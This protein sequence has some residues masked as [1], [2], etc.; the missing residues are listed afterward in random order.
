MA[1]RNS[2]QSQVSEIAIQHQNFV[3]RELPVSEQRLKSRSLTA[4]LT[5]STQKIFK[6]SI[7]VPSLSPRSYSLLTVSSRQ[8]K[9]LC[10]V[11]GPAPSYIYRI[12]PLFRCFCNLLVRVKPVK[13][14]Q[15]C[16][17]GK[18]QRHHGGS[19]DKPPGEGEGNRLQQQSWFLRLF[20]LQHSGEGHQGE[21]S[22]CDGGP[23]G[24]MEG[25]WMAFAFLSG[26]LALSGV[27]EKTQQDHSLFLHSEK[28]IRNP[29]MT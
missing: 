28:N 20:H 14:F 16:F 22:L 1:Q 11:A 27:R 3:Q 8:L 25:D 5:L 23:A 10:R 19:P 7:T 24:C 9:L 4:C 15:W 17:W 18:T 6:S 26:P 21:N 12:S 2:E 29:E 13:G